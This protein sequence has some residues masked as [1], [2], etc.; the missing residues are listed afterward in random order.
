MLKIRR[1]WDRLIFNIGIPILERHLYI[2]TAPGSLRS[3]GIQSHDVNLVFP[4]FVVSAPEWWMFYYFLVFSCM[5]M[6]ARYR[7]VPPFYPAALK[8][9]GVLSYPERADGRAAG[10]T[11]PVNTLTSIIFY[12][13]FSNL[14]RTFVTLRSRDKF[15]QWGSASLNMR[16]I[17]H[18][19]SRPL[20][21]F[22]NSFFKL[23][24]PNLAHR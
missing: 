24:S 22:L 8:G 20:L 10:Q 17:D 18:L 16:I 19:M 2:D 4:D 21:T 5:C 13:S 23:K 11:S 9:S 3:Q 1:S 6:Q 7:P 15:D 14:A 12:G